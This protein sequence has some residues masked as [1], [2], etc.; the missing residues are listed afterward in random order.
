MVSVSSMATHQ[1]A[2]GLRAAATDGIGLQPLFRRIE[3][4]TIPPFTS[5]MSSKT[6]FVPGGIALDCRP[7]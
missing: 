1:P 4:Q 7:A 2:T 3:P 5:L 6:L